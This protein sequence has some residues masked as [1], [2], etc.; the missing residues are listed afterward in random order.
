MKS[1][2]LGEISWSLPGALAEAGVDA[3]ILVPAYA[4]LHRAFPAAEPVATFPAPGGT[5][6][7]ARLLQA[8]AGNGV[9]LL[10]LECEQYYRRE[11]TAYLDANGNDFGDN[12]LRF[13]LLS[14]VAALLGSLPTGEDVF[15]FGDRP[16]SADV[17]VAVL[18]ARLKMIGQYDALLA[19][20]QR[21]DAWY[22]RYRARDIVRQADLWE[23]FQPLRI[24]TKR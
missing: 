7:P 17:V 8:R 16:G 5:L 15:L 19:G 3:R 23:R 9:S 4:P 24:L 13:G 22:A 18:L 2:G 10:L 21:V 6:A 12:H 1:G 14:R 20:H 11:G